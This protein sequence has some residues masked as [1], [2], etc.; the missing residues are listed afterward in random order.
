MGTVPHHILGRAGAR[1]P[2]DGWHP[3]A[4]DKIGELISLNTRLQRKKASIMSDDK[5][6]NPVGRGRGDRGVR[7]R[8]RATNLTIDMP[9]GG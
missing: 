4:L 3:S 9:P 6:E 1:L 7:G 5:E 2:P 8:A